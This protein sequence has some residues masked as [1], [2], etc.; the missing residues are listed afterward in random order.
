MCF[1]PLLWFCPVCLENY[2]ACQH[3]CK[4]HRRP[5]CT[6]HTGSR[7]RCTCVLTFWKPSLYAMHLLMKILQIHKQISITITDFVR[8]HTHVKTKTRKFQLHPPKYF[9]IFRIMKI[10]SGIAL[11]PL[12]SSACV[13][14]SVI[15]F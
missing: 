1:H 7:V 9:K 8:I 5:V 15:G 11:L 2:A 14:L 12:I 3:W 10:R 6:N 13:K 4:S